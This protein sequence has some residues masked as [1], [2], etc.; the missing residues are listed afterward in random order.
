MNDLK[1][2]VIRNIKN[3]LRDKAAVFFSFLSIIILVALYF[4]FIGNNFR[5]N[6]LAGLLTNQQLDF[7][8]YSQLI[9]GLI[10]INTAS[11]PIGNLGNIINDFEYG[12][13]NSLLVTPVKRYKITL[14]YYISSFV[15]T[16]VLSLMLIIFAF[17][18]IGITTFRFYSFDIWIYTIL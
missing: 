6:E 2:L 9:P 12:Q 7:M 8:V 1:A 10:V 14:G 18:I 4:M 17:L 3:F 13:V 16:F 11:I 5:P 15:I